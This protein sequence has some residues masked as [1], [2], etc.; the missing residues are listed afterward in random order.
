MLIMYFLIK[1]GANLDELKENFDNKKVI[2]CQQPNINNPFMNI[3]PT[4]NRDRLSACTYDK[5]TKDEI[6]DA[7]NTNLY[8]DL[9]DIYG[10]NNSQRQFYTMPS[11]TIPNKQDSFAKWLYNTPSICKEGNC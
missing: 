11:T 2:S 9:N 1:W 4:D 8:L 10:K 6:N 3:L 7:F 5:K